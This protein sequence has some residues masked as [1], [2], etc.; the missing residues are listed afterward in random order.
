MYVNI[1][2]YFVK[3]NIASNAQV[4]YLPYCNLKHMQSCLLQS[5]IQNASYYRRCSSQLT[6]VGLYGKRCC[7]VWHRGTDVLEHNAVSFFR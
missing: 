4:L 5:I 2:S 3:F 6:I 7:V 1:Q